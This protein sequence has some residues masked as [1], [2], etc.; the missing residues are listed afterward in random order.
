MDSEFYSLL[1]QQT[2]SLVPPL[3]D[4]NVVTC[5]W[6]YK[7]K[8]HSDGTITRYKARLVVKGYLYQYG[9]DYEETF[10]PVVKPTIVRLLLALAVKYGWPFKQLDV[11]N[12]FLHDILKEVVYMA[13]PQGYVDQSCPNHVC[14]LHK[15][16]YVL[17]QAPKAWFERF[18]SQLLHVGFVAFRVD[19]N[20][21]IYNH[22]SHLVFLLLYVD[23]I[24]VTGNHP[25]FISSLLGVLS[26]DFDLKDLGRLHYF[27]GL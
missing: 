13:Q 23:D 14:L 15:A 16:L 24:I 25:D 2:W 27:L 21:F 6:V 1:K 20:L 8:R 18:T 4:K 19:G 12:A 3:V 22:A 17:K 9:L 5:K 26:N 11:S 7:L 10:S